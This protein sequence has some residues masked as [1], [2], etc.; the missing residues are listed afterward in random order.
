MPQLDELLGYKERHYYMVLGSG[1]HD[2]GPRMPLYAAKA[3]DF[4]TW[5]FLG[6]LFDVAGNFS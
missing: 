1:I 4:T 3:S 5:T 6:A 2:A